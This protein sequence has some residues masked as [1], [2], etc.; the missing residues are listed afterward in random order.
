MRH[1][2]AFVAVSCCVAV[3]TSAT[4]DASAGGVPSRVV[5]VGA[6][7]QAAELDLRSPLSDEAYY[8]VDEILI[9]VKPNPGPTAYKVTIIPV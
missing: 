3:A 4:L 9:Q 7:G 1:R 5:A 8:K 6:D 2:A